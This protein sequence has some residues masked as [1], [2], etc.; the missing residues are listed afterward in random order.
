MVRR[1]ATLLGVL[2]AAS[3]LFASPAGAVGGEG[4][5]W[6]AFTESS[7]CGAQRLSPPHAESTGWLSR[8]TILRGPAASMFGRTVQQ[9]FS[10]LVGWRVPGSTETLSVHPRMVPALE[11]AAASIQERLDAGET[12]RIS[13]ESTFGTAA[14]TIAGQIRMSRH[15]FGTA[16]DF[17]ATR[18]P[19][20]RDNVL[21]TD[22][23]S[24]WTEAFLDAGFCWGGLWIGSKDT[25]HFS[26]Q[27]P[28]FTEG[29][30]LPLP[31]APLTTRQPFGTPD[32]RTLVEPRPMPFTF[33]TVLADG[34]GNG[35]TDV[36]RLA[37]SN[38][39]VIVDVSVA[40]RQHNACSAR[41]SIADRPAFLLACAR[42]AADQAS[43]ATDRIAGRGLPV[44]GSL[45]SRACVGGLAVGQ[46]L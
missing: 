45:S 39:D 12:Y 36:V 15:T 18:N 40:S 35:A 9:V 37:Q 30:E 19:N 10:D 13:P 25:M 1:I 43:R 23:P 28:A 38:G 27:G 21:V 34:D 8:D 2:T 26:W 31:Y 14:R 46:R 24:W 42:R 11:V 16:M 5:A 41:R 22:M 3:M 20:R 29:V 17:N 44:S 7:G 6:P 32:E 33:A 4:E